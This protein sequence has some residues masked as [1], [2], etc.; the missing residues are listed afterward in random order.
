MLNFEGH[1]ALACASTAETR[2]LLRKALA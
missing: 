2:S 1:P